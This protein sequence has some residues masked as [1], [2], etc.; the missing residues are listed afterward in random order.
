MKAHPT[1]SSLHRFLLFSFVEASALRLNAVTSFSRTLFQSFFNAPP[2]IH[3]Q[4]Q[5][6]AHT[7]AVN[8]HSCHAFFTYCKCLEV[9]GEAVGI[10]T[11]STFHTT[12]TS[13][14]LCM[15]LMNKSAHTHTQ[16]SNS[17]FLNV[18][19]TLLHRNIIQ[20]RMMFKDLPII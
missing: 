19:N 12:Q 8:D 2:L 3:R 11:T 6:V 20:K 9:H 10:E 1:T 5:D 13:S 16:T 18:S 4:R 17:M 7:H 14:P 15:V